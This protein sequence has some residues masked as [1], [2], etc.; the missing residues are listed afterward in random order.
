MVTPDTQNMKYNSVAPLLGYNQVFLYPVLL[1]FLSI[2]YPHL[3]S[4]SV[5]SDLFSWERLDSS[6]FVCTS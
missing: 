6:I 1:D 5:K 2:Y 3:L 4:I